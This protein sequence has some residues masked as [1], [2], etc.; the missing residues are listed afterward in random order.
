MMLD[1]R[2]VEKIL[3]STEYTVINS[4]S[5]LVNLRTLLCVTE[6]NKMTIRALSVAFYALSGEKTKRF[7]N[8]KQTI[9]WLKNIIDAHISDLKDA[10]DYHYDW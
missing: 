9:R 6:L 10:G 4:R 1:K 2:D 5:S 3:L 8:K 7:R